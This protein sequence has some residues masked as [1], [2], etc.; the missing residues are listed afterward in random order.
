MLANVQRF[1]KSTSMKGVPRI[2]TS[3]SVFLRTV[4]ICAV[5]S[6]FVFGMY[7]VA[8]FAFFGAFKMTEETNLM[9]KMI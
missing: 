7:Q 4:W 5:I 1:G 3:E 9:Q 8:F 2:L 6:F